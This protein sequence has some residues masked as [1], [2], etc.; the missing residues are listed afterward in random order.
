MLKSMRE[1]FHQLKWILLAVVAAFII[2]FVY[3]D[4]GLGGAGQRS[5][6][7]D[8]SFAARVNGST[9]TYNEFQRSLSNAEERYKQMYGGQFSKELEDAMGLDRQVL[10]SLVDQRLML[11]EARRLHM[12]ATPEEVRRKILEIPALNQGGHWGGDDLYRRYAQIY[13][14]NSPADFEDDLARQLTIDKMESALAN[15]I[16]VSPKAA[17]NEYK[18]ISENARI[19][20]VLYSGRDSISAIKV[21]PAEELAYYN[22]NQSKYTHGEQRELKYLVSDTVRMRMGINPT[23]QQIRQRYEST[24]EQYK[25]P[26]QAHILHILVKVDPKATP[27]EDAVLRAKA[28]GI[29]KQLRAGGDFAALA[30]ANSQDPSSSGNGGDM[31]YIDRGATVQPFDDAAFS[32]PLNQISDP[33]RSQ[34]FGYHIIKVLDRRAAGYRPF[35]EVK[36]QV[37]SQL[38]NEMALQQATDEMAKVATRMKSKAPASAVEFASYANDKVSSND[39]QWFQKGSSLPGLGFNQPLMTWAFSAKQGEMSPI[40][41][42]QRGPTMAYLAGVRPAGVTAFEEVK[43][44]VENDA[45][46]AQAR[47]LAKQKLAAATVGAAKIDDVGAKLGLTAQEISVN[48]QAAI[49]TIPGDTGALVDLALSAPVGVVQPPLIAGDGAVAFQ[50]VEQKKATPADVQQNRASYIEQMRSQEARNLRGS[51]LQRLRKSA[52]I[53]V[54]DKVLSQQ[55]GN[56]EGA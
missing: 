53:I 17:E 4:M 52:K 47:V 8:R 30:K 20:Y 51:L 14:Y 43:A 46:A 19:R 13:G 34:E 9:I 6:A 48:R 1:S 39:T 27:A 31:G 10:E 45:K 54:N 15:S 25:R 23:E 12:E 41:R 18:R 38:A 3:V 29:V 32:I 5:K 35:E 37:G 49:P 55:K 2:G 40:T 44:Q 16:V 56:Q 24:K 28:E 42:T 22:A 26:E 7:D 50:V 11:Q 21:T 33:I 36:L